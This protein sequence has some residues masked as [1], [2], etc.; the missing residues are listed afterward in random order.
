MKL[1]VCKDREYALNLLIV[2][3]SMSISIWNLRYVRMGSTP[4]TQ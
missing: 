2:S 1:K 3:M 4:V